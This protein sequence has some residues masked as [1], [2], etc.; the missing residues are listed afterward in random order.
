MWLVFMRVYLEIPVSSVLKLQ[1]LIVFEKRKFL[2]QN[3][4]HMS[5]KAAVSRLIW[6]GQQT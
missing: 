5:K 1:G 3:M 2:D 6:V 4:L